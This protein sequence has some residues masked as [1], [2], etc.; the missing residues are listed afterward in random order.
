MDLFFN[1]LSASSLSGDNVGVQVGCFIR[2]ISSAIS[3]GFQ[4][5]R[6]EKGLS[7]VKIGYNRTLAQY[8][9][10]HSKEQDVR[11]L[12]AIQRQPFLEGDQVDTFLEYED[13]RIRDVSCEGLA[14]AYINKSMGVGF[15]TSEWTDLK[16]DLDLIIKGE[17]NQRCSVLCLSSLDHFS[18]HLYVNWANQKLPPPK[19]YKSKQIPLD[20]HI[21]LSP[22]H[23]ISILMEFSHRLRN[24]PYVEEIVNSTDRNTDS[25]KFIVSMHDNLIEMRLVQQ[26]GY[27]I[28]VR[29]TARNRRQLEAIAK[30]LEE[31]FNR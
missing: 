5:V 10:S 3:D 18:N 28:I 16:Y 17:L 30:H 14:C 25:D 29:T 24:D 6:F 13:F 9:Y 31:R 19:L 15:C 23:G 27:G 26:G 21:H 2:V 7:G 8:C 22:H 1:E 12:L 20:K 11:T 4:H